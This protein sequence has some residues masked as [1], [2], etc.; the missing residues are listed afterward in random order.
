MTIAK[1]VMKLL[2]QKGF[3]VDHTLDGHK[4][5]LL[6][7]NNDYDCIILDLN[8]PEMD[9]MEIAKRIRNAEIATPILMLTARTSIDDRLEGFQA[10]ADDYLP[11]PFELLELIARVSAIIRRNSENKK[12]KMLFEDYEV[13]VEQNCLINNK[14]GESI[15]LSQKE[16]GVLEYLLRHRGKTVSAEELLSHVWDTNVNMFTDTVK[17]HIKTLRQKLGSLG[18]LIQTIKG[19][20]YIIR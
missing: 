11:K 10:G 9:G 4:G 13:V 16:I 15:V 6:A 2:M 5:L 17:T 12:A 19:K 20:G 14:S 18:K 1:P 8:L 7:L 3:M